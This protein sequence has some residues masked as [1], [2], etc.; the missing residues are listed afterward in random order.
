MSMNDD[1]QDEIPGY[2]SKGARALQKIGRGKP[3]IEAV[4]YWSC[5]SYPVVVGAKFW[6][7]DMRVCQVTEIGCHSNAYADTG[8]TQTW[9]QTGYGQF[10]TLSGS[11]QKFGRLV[12]HVYGSKGLQERRGL[13][14]RH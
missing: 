6:N 2:T 11:M 14:G 7:N 10:D 1:R 5:D 8:E 3:P 12:R 9:H 13:P 4:E